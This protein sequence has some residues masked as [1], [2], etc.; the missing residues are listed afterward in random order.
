M[1]AP[2]QGLFASL[3]ILSFALHTILIV[4]ATNYYLKDTR[5]I[6]GELLTR[7][8]V[9]DSLNELEPPNT[10]ALALLSSRYATNPG[11]SSLRILDKSDR[12]LAT[13][14]ANKTRQGEIFVRDALLNEKKIGRIE[15]TL[16]QPS[17]GEQLRNLWLPILVTLII[18]ALLWLGYRTIARPTRSEFMAKMKREAQLKHEIN[19]LADALEQEKH[20]TSLAIAKIQQQFQKPKFQLETD[21]N[22]KIEHSDYIFL[23][24]QFYDPKQLLGTVHQTTAQNYFNTVQ[25]LLNKTIGLCKTHYQLGENDLEVIQPFFDDGALVRIHKNVQ[26]AIVALIQVAVVFQFLSDAMYKRCRD[27]KRFGLQTRCAV[28]EE[29]PNMQLT[30]EK[31]AIRLGQYLHAKETA[32]YLSKPTFKDVRHGYDFISL[33]NPSNA[34]TREAVLLQGL[35]TESAQLA[36][37]MRTEILLGR[38]VRQDDV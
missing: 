33:P 37:E 22:Q 38:K 14:G 5:A 16:I 35:N 3:L 21:P 26:H 24:V 20:Q 11:I 2:R 31:A 13:A 12:V 27:E 6:Q 1:N 8:L 19:R 30:P 7:Q 4:L 23:S 9:N 18:H 10:V 15:V 29:L 28:A 32:I 25:T 34:L 17:I 36:Q